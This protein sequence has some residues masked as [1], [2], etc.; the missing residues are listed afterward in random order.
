MEIKKKLLDVFRDKIRFKHY[1]YSTERTYIYWVKRYI[2]FHNKKHPVN[3]AKREI[4]MKRALTL[5]E[6]TLS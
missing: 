1:S 2:F 5:K 6:F 4:E 3:M